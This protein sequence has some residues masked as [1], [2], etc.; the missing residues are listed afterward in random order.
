MVRAFAAVITGRG[1]GGGQDGVSLI[2]DQIEVALEIARAV[3]VIALA[4]LGIAVVAN[5]ATRH[6]TTAGADHQRRGADNGLKRRCWSVRAL[7]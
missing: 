1:R 5:L 4:A 6:G 3:I 7:A 2:A